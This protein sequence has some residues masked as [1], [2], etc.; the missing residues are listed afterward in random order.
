MEARMI[1]TIDGPAGA[2]KSTAARETAR[3]LGFTFVD[4]G[5][6]YRAVGVAARRAGM[7]RD[8]QVGLTALAGRVKIVFVHDAAGQRVMLDGS[9]VTDEIRT[10]ESSMWASW[11]SAVPGVRSGLLSLQR[12]LAGR[13]GAVLE[14]RDTGTVVFPD[15]AMKFFID[16]SPEVR[17]GRRYDELRSKGMD[18]RYEKILSDTIERDRNDSTRATAP[19]R[20]PADAVRVDTDHMDAAQVVEFMVETAKKRLS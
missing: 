18:V 5:A 3:R 11:V 15:A 14:G 9:D 4:T 17:A 20:C 12:D 10:P 8:D 19:L 2:G 16:A 13:G 6:I 7:S 1:V